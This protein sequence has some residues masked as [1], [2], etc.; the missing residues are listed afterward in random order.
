MHWPQAAA[1]FLSGGKTAQSSGLPSARCPSKAPG[2]TGTKTRTP[3]LRKGVWIPA[4]L[5][6]AILLRGLVP[7]GWMP[8]VGMDGPQLVICTTSG[9]VAAP[10][11]M[12]APGGDPAPPA[13]VDHSP[14]AFAGLGMPILPAVAAIVTACAQMI[15]ESAP[16]TGPPAAVDSAR[17]HI[18]PPAQA[19][20]AQR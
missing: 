6:L 4:L 10:A 16:P 20:P 13:S 14:C 11:E 8:A 3:Q 1:A 7:V 2:V 19:P 9:L 5:L 15:L 12:F 17:S 18:R